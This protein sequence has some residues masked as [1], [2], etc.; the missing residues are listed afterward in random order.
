M[1]E[2]ELMQDEAI[3]KLAIAMKKMSVEYNIPVSEMISEG[4]SL[5]DWLI[6]LPS[7]STPY[8]LKIIE[9]AKSNIQN[10]SE[11]QSLDNLSEVLSSNPCMTREGSKRINA[12]RMSFML[13]SMSTLTID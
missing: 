8:V 12:A 3:V 4:Y 13:A 7:V 9:N 2:K 10:E 1:T 5:L 6:K 11:R